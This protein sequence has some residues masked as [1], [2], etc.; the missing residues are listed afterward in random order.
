MINTA[1]QNLLI[2]VA[3]PDRPGIT[4][5]LMKL[6]ARSPHEVIDM[7]QAVTHGLLS[8]SIVIQFHEAHDGQGQGLL[9]DLLFEA[10]TMGLALT[11]QL[12][13]AEQLTTDTPE[14]RFIVSCVSELGLNSVF[15]HAMAK[16]LALK[17]INIHR[18]DKISPRSLVGLEFMTSL[19]QGLDLE[20]IKSDLIALSAEHKVDVAFLKDN[21]FRRAKRLV[22]FDMDSTLIQAEVIDELALLAGSGEHVKEIT[23]KAMNGELD[24]R[25]S[26]IERVKTLEGL[27]VSQLQTVLDRLPLTPGVQDFIR[28]IKSLGF[29]VAI[30]SG[31]FS[32]FTDALKNKLGIDYAFGNELEIKNNKLTGKVSGTIIDAD[33]KA[34][35]LKFIAQQEGIH[36]EQ[37]VAIG[38]GANDLPML[39]TAGLGIAFHAK[40][41][42]RKSA[43]NHMSHGPMTSILYFLGIPGAGNY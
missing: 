17:K 12:V 3:G 21:V 29:K 9:K 22:V 35:L 14:E 40:D 30:I 34:F 7:G 38:D 27:D 43:Q 8:L 41:H 36:L 26:L 18:I 20:S 28:T 24:F 10:S 37:V 16:S 1:D 31:G 6:I 42:V 25:Q 2:H 13:Q 39:A 32:F 19:P 15:I 5:S 33:Q 23:E 4:E 11:Y